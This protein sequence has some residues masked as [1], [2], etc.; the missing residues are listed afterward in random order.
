M[1]AVP[2]LTEVPMH[3]RS[4]LAI[5]PVALLTACEDPLLPV[6]RPTPRADVS[7]TATLAVT[8]TADTDDGS[9]DA[10]CSLR[11][12]IAAA[13]AAPGSTITFGAT[14]TFSLPL[15]ELVISAPMTIA[16][17]GVGDVTV[18]AAGQTR[19]LLLSGTGGATVAISGLTIADG[20]VNGP[21]GC[22]QSQG[23]RL[24]LTE[25]HVRDCRSQGAGGGIGSTGEGA[26]AG[27]VT[28]DRV[29]VTGS[30][31]ANGG[32]GVY[33]DHSSHLHVVASTIAGNEGREGGGV[34]TT[35]YGVMFNSTVSGNRA[36]LHGGGVYAADRPYDG[37]RV[38][39]S[40]IVG[41]TA[42]ADGDGT[43]DGGGIY[44]SGAYFAPGYSII[45]NNADEG[46]EAPD[47]AA[48]NPDVYTA[49]HSL[50][51]LI[52]DVTGCDTYAAS[53]VVVGDPELG[54]LADNGGATLTHLPVTGS[55][56]IDALG[57]SCLPDDQRGFARPVGAGCD[58]G[59]V[60]VQAVTVQIDV[61]PGSATNPVS[62]KAGGTLPVAVLSTADF[63]ARTIVVS[64]LRLN[65]QPVAPRPKAQGGGYMASY[66][67][68]N[69]DGRLDLVVHFTVKQVVSSTTTSLTLAGTSTAVGAISGSDVVTVVP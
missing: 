34:G 4:A 25:V 60:E 28:L 23:T 16:G 33:N 24:I 29:S 66:E 1:K 5:L 26:F 56:A 12:A 9:C 69:G 53:A 57:L 55:P 8:K 64:S 42:D 67:D 47:C 65:G 59:A 20:D 61:K 49:G 3:A 36:R 38:M 50:G 22:I 63:D 17:P 52:G 10:D 44:N 40:T 18:R 58:I 19:V 13:N 30:W 43:G 35:G 21:G 62:L 48:V 27:Y 14:G 68:V 46:G 32:G 15:G 11:E 39:M 37:V 54:P 6:E 7:S 31:A 51:N 45:A 41:N 2:T